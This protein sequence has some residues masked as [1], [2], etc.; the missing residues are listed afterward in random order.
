MDKWRGGEKRRAVWT[1]DERVRRL[2][3]GVAQAIMPIMASPLPPTS[4]LS[5]VG[6]S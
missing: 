6:A 5:G 2:E 3:L 1:S 4:V